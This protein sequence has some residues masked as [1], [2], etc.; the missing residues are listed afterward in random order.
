L[1]AGVGGRRPAAQ[2]LDVQEMQCVDGL[3][4]GVLQG[5]GTT[6]GGVNGTKKGAVE[7]RGRIVYGMN[8]SAGGVRPPQHQAT[9]VAVEDVDR[10]SAVIPSVWDF[11]DKCK[12]NGQKPACL[13]ARWQKMVRTSPKSGLLFALRW[14]L[15][16]CK[17]MGERERAQAMRSPAQEGR[18]LG[19]AGWDGWLVGQRPGR[20]R[21]P[22]T[23]QQPGRWGTLGGRGLSVGDG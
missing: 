4:G 14:W 12:T 7:R 11:D 22:S 10:G 21:G 13:L 20:V 16:W 8:K 9:V 2:Q 15:S 23:Q 19:K 17:V 3:E 6:S 1:L 18:D 5:R